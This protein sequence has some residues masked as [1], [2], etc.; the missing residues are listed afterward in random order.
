MGIG[1]RV[2]KRIGIVFCIFAS[3][4][5]CLNVGREI[6]FSGYSNLLTFNYIS[7]FIYPLVFGLSIKFYGRIFKFAQIICIGGEGILTLT[8]DPLNPFFGLLFVFVALL[9]AYSYGYFDRW[10]IFKGISLSAFF[11]LMF[12]LFPFKDTQTPFISGSMWVLCLAVI[13]FIL[14]IIFKDFVE[15]YKQQS[16]L[17][18]TKL[19]RSLHKLQNKLDEYSD[20]SHISIETN[21]ELLEIVKSHLG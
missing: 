7:Y 15:D 18:E 17:R 4:I 13:I 14:W 21:R 16:Q 11:T 20:V 10:K 19:R 8:S 2:Q 6:Y 5:L 9:L 3:V 12:A 1:D